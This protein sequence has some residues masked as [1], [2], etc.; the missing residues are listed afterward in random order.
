MNEKRRKVTEFIL[1]NF[2]KI[3]PGDKT[4]SESLKAAFDKMSDSEF[5][6]YIKRLAPAKT[7]DEIKQRLFLPFYVPNLRPNG[8]RLSIARNYQI[9]RDLGRSIEERL[10]MTDGATGLKYITP[11]AYPVYDLQVR[12]QAQTGSKKRSIPEHH[13]R[14]DDLTDQPTVDSKGSRISSPEFGSLIQKRLDNTVIE[15]THVRGGNALAA[16]EFT[17]ALVEDGEVNLSQL[18]GLGI[19]R[20]TKTLSTFLNTMLIGNNLDPSTKVPDDARK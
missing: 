15:L 1:K 6:A 17:R 12:R 7:P 5:E 11:H 20:S 13:Q 2:D 18:E 10:I 8:V 4:N 19:A 3:L 9:A 14:L 16:R